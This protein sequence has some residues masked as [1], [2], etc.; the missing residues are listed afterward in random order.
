MLR[1]EPQK[2]QLYVDEQNPSLLRAAEEGSSQLYPVAFSQDQRAYFMNKNGIQQRIFFVNSAGYA[3]FIHREKEQRNSNFTEPGAMCAY[4]AE[5]NIRSTDITI[6][7]DKL[8]IARGELYDIYAL[9][10]DDSRVARNNNGISERPS[11]KNLRATLKENPAPYAFNEQGN[12]PLTAWSK[13]RNFVAGFAATTFLLGVAGAI[14]L[15]V[16]LF[17]WP[18]V[19]TLFSLSVATLGI[20]GLV[21]AFSPAA[22]NNYTPLPRISTDFSQKIE[23]REVKDQPREQLSV[24]PTPQLDTPLGKA[25]YNP[26]L[27]NKAENQQ[28]P[29]SIAVSGP[30]KE[31][32]HALVK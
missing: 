13:A 8:K 3:V 20:Y 9:A 27:F 22:N 28:Q 29:S 31:R 16:Y 19:V 4:N 11:F 5:E 2:V 7:G 26:T 32:E 24:K 25:T 21:K 1:H 18:V 23:E 15:S 30:V 14:A 12:K 10:L 6:W 17:L